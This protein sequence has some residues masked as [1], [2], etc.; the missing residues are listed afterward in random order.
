[1]F[2]CCGPQWVLNF[3]RE[4]T[5]AAAANGW[6]VLVSHLVEV[7]KYIVRYVVIRLLSRHVKM[8]QS[9]V[10]TKTLKNG[11]NA[12]T[13]CLTD[14]LQLFSSSKHAAYGPRVCDLHLPPE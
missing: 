2:D 5:G 8:N 3:D 11:S 4:G 6:S 13:L 12:A 10:S 1:M 14:S 9:E 7:K